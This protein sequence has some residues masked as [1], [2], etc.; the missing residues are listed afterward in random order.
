[1]RFEARDTEAENGDVA[2]FVLR[3]SPTAFV[4][5]CYGVP[6]RIAGRDRSSGW[7]RWRVLEDLH[8]H[9]GWSRRPDLNW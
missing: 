1:M 3:I 2:E 9:E 6:F 7:R 5:A 4:G 8:A